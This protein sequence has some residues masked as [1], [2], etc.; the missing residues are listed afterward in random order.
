MGMLICFCLFVF[1]WFD[2]IDYD[3]DDDD[4]DD[5][6]VG[7]HGELLCVVGG[8]G[9]EESDNHLWKDLTCES[10]LEN[11]ILDCVQNMQ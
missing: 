7:K 9:E 8:G 2:D 10:V 3:N 4:G 5:D 1:G 11:C 6:D